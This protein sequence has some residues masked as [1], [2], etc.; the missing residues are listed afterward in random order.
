MAAVVRSWS[1]ESHFL[2]QN[3]AVF[4]LTEHLNNL[5]HL[6]SQNPRAAL[7]EIPLPDEAA[8]VDVFRHFETRFPKALATF[9]GRP[10]FPAARLAGAT[11][12]SIESLLK[13]QEYAGE[14][15]GEDDLAGLK[16]SLV[17]KDAQGLIEFLEPV[18][19]L[20][21]VH[22]SDAVKTWMRQDLALWREGE[23]AAMPMGYLFCGPV[24]T[25]KS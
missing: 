2:E 17:E 21:D 4:L 12:G 23:L 6:L 10:E 16:K 13:Q 14:P 3:L 5:N 19:T 1:H 22:G 11:V 9:A 25:G 7:V 24:G 8:L 20:D 18:R 15:L